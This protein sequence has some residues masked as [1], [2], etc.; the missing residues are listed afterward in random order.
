[1]ED[2]RES[3]AVLSNQEDS[4]L[5][6]HG[7]SESLSKPNKHSNKDVHGMQVPSPDSPSQ[8]GKVRMT[9]DSSICY[10]GKYL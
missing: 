6:S 4:P 3:L 1:M 2:L 9:L 5:P 10:H 7:R 8:R